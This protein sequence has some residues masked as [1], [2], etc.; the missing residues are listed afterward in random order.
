MDSRSEEGAMQDRIST[1]SELCDE[2]DRAGENFAAIRAVTLSAFEDL[3]NVDDRARRVLSDTGMESPPP[4]DVVE[5]DW[6][7][8]EMTHRDQR[9]SEGRIS[10]WWVS[11]GVAALVGAVLA[12][13]GGFAVTGFGGVPD[14]AFK[15]VGVVS[16]SLGGFELALAPVYLSIIC[17]AVGVILFVV[18]ALL[19]RRMRR[20]T[21]RAVADADSTMKEAM[22]RMEANGT[23]LR[24]LANSAKERSEELSRATGAIQANM[25][26]VTADRIYRGL[27]EAAKLYSTLQDPIPHAHLYIG[28]PSPLAALSSIETTPTSVTVAWEDPDLG[29]SSIEGYQVRQAGGLF[30]RGRYLST[31]EETQFVHTELKTGKTYTY[32]II[33]FNSI[34]EATSNRKF[35]ARTQ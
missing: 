29:A 2:H 4:R 32:R 28:R 3:L 7:S 31:V 16:V 5:V 35:Q 21:A 9:V 34:G 6:F 26:Q 25:N 10:G 23:R 17:L 24:E 15:W 27:R 19:R 30:R 33:P 11:A 12:L 20:R 13:L 22:D 14:G 8:D 18:A 1:H